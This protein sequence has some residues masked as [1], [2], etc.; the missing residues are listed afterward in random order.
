M[1]KILIVSEELNTDKILSNLLNDV[2]YETMIA[3]SE[4]EAF[5][6]TNTFHPDIAIVDT[7]C[8]QINISSICKKLKL[9][10]KQMI[11]KLFYLHQKILLQKKYLLELM[12]I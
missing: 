9:Q 2:G 12:V 4:E 3:I 1:S 7:S 6:I 11:Y 8:P 10:A 5:S